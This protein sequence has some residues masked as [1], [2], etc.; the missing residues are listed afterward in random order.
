[1]KLSTHDIDLIEKGIEGSLT[2]EEALEFERKNTEVEEFRNAVKFQKKLLGSLEAHQKNEIKKELKQLFGDLKAETS[3]KK[4]LGVSRWYLAAASIVLLV[5]VAWIIGVQRVNSSALFEKY[6]EAYPAQG[7]T[8]GEPLESTNEEII[9]LYS[10]RN[11]EEIIEAIESQIALGKSFD[12]QMLYLGNA[13]L[14]KL[15]I[16]EA[17]RSFQGIEEG[18]RYYFDAQWYL[19]LSYLQDSNSRGA[20][21]ILSD[22]EAKN[23]IYGSSARKLLEELK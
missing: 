1:M 20:I 23:S 12:G 6:Y 4:I 21:R 16:E 17:I 19:A 11:Y 8:R 9:Q 18:S 5:G 10:E 7:T 13:Y 22:L 3:S 2:K 15:K 14:A